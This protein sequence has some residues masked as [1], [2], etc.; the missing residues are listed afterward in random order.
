MA[1]CPTCGARNPAR[2]RFCLEC[3]TRLADS[4]VGARG[5][6]SGPAES[7]RT[8]TVLF[9]DIVGS[10]ELGESIDPEVVRTAISRAFVAMR[11]TIERH[12]GTVEKFIGDAVMAIFGLPTLHED[13]A[14]RA[15]RAASELRDGLGA[16]GEDLTA[17]LGRSLAVR[18]GVN[19][20]EV[21]V[22]D[23]LRGETLATGDTVN[24]AA[25]L[26][27]AAGRGE[28]LL[29]A[30]TAR[31]L[32]RVASLQAVEP[33]AAKGKA[34][35]VPAFRLV[36]IEEA[37]STDPT[38]SDVPFVGRESELARLR[39]AFDAA[40]REM[41]PRIVTVLG[42]PGV[43]K[44]R[45]VAELL[46][47]IGDR[48]RIL[49]GRCLSY[50]DGL[51]YWPLREMV[52]AA[53]GTDD[54]DTGDTVPV[55]LQGLVGGDDAVVI[56]DCLTTGI[57]LR[58]GTVSAEEIAWAARRTFES[59]ATERPLVLVVED[60]HWAR[61]AMRELLDHVVR[62][63]TG[64]P[65][66][67]V[68]PARQDLLDSAPEWGKGPNATTIELEGL[69]PEA[70]ERLIESVAGSSAVVPE[71]LRR[72]ILETA[73][74]NPLFVEEMVRLVVETGDASL[75]IPP[76]IEA[77]MATRIDRLP[78]SERR[79]A[80]R[81]SVVGRVFERAAVSALLPEDGRP[82]L[83]ARLQ[84]LVR[85][86]LLR[87]ERPRMADAAAFK[88]RHILIRDAA[89]NALAKAERAEL[90]EVFATWL[91]GTIAG[92]PGEY[93]EI[94]GY[95]FEQA[96]RYRVELRET[97]EQ[98][99]ALAR[100]AGRRLGAAARSTSDRGDE[101][102][103]VRLFDRATRLPGWEDHERGELLVRW[104]RSL[105]TVGELASA[106]ERADEALALAAAGNRGVAAQA[107]IARLEARE[108]SG[109]VVNPSEEVRLETERAL[110]DAEASGDARAQ[111]YAWGARSNYTYLLGDLEASMVETERAIDWGMRIGN[112][113]LVLATGQVRLT[114]ALVGSTP[115]TAVVAM[116]EEMLGQAAAY[117]PARS[118]VLR[119]IAPA[120]AMLGRF[121]AARGHY[122]EALAINHDLRR[123]WESIQDR[124]D[125][126]WVERLAGDLAAAEKLLRSGLADVDRMGDRTLHAF[127]ATR[128]AVVLVATGRFEEATGLIADGESI[129]SI[130][131]RS[132]VMGAQARIKAAAGDM[133]ARADVEA[134]L[135]PL[136]TTGFMNVKTDALV[137]AAEVMA[138]L[139]DRDAAVR[140]FS[141][142]LELCER[143]ENL[144][145]A[146][147]LRSRLA[148]LAAPA[149]WRD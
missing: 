1:A 85:K 131:N 145:L 92:A 57:G 79:V 113:R 21:V 39:S 44:S 53:V 106:L 111:W 35:P 34:E 72:R 144:A 9:A 134:M 5:S 137:D 101:L 55:A 69:T 138:A 89:Y 27:Q 8:V 133:D 51:T 118:D 24:T 141:E 54:V 88:F 48:A 116:A 117:P 81:G 98:V 74:G 105:L 109:M 148:S 47:D 126:S 108:T 135:D 56:A 143:K 68:C 19:T 29:G 63:A 43:G 114:M 147:Q 17:R 122:R 38:T 33:I 41:S 65:I 15:V 40:A 112:E 32:R 14:L 42:A 90:H 110:D 26:E 46:D 49:R 78:A 139:G 52:L 119:L 104:S 125:A 83:A 149:L 45:L 70:G 71:P 146:D 102:A 103:A 25:R 86:Q 61:P 77:L 91:A 75:A 94:V 30:V 128:L 16:L 120:E 115:A 31:L 64:A 50:G 136:A 100:E 140:Y 22:G 36:S 123:P 66:L 87:R 95:H 80:Q 76:T 59:L 142:A 121:D 10:T 96:Y 4:S 73:E 97:G 20:G 2:A 28:I 84:T 93:D 99:A 67:V 18:I 132:R 124:L 13:D 127:A 130:T 62:E 6:S 82:G 58:E 23:P 107:R 11:A 37:G 60:I 7:R 12:G 129:P 3:G